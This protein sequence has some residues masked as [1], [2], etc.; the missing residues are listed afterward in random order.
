MEQTVIRL[1]PIGPIGS[2]KTTI[3]NEMVSRIGGRRLSFAYAMKKEVAE[4]LMEIISGRMGTYPAEAIGVID[5]VL[6]TLPVDVFER[7]LFARDVSQVIDLLSDP[8]TKTWF[9]AAQ[10]WWGTEYRRAQDKDYWVRQLALQINELHDKNLFVEDCRFPNEYQ[11]LEDTGFKFV[12]LDRNPAY[13]YD[14]ER[15]SHESERYFSSFEYHHHLRWAG[16]E[17]RVNEVVNTFVTSPVS[18]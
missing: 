18:S 2:G 11:L 16:I 12:L 4:A 7:I 9:R 3:C 8:T 13:P 14:A 15:D 1:A 17:D 10:Q 5:T 6:A